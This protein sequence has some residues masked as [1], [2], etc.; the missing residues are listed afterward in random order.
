MEV[1]TRQTNH[2]AVLAELKRIHAENESG[3]LMPEEVVEAA[4]HPDSP[5]HSRFEW[6]DSIAAEKFRVDQAR[7]L[8]IKF[9][10]TFEKSEPQRVFY[11]LTKDR[12]DGG[13]YRTVPDIK[14]F[15]KADARKSA[16][17]ELDQWARRHDVFCE[18][19]VAAVRKAVAKFQ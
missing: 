12:T 4:R 1:A 9:H 8:I 18:D 10:V 5:L 15:H 19:I 2:D 11:S 14:K 3:L 6:D 17:T 16:L 13:G 7:Q